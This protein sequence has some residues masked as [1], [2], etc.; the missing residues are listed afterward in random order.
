MRVNIIQN[1]FILN[2]DLFGDVGA[3]DAHGHSD[4]GLLERGRVVD[5]VAR[6]RH[7]GSQPLTAL[8]D[9]QFLLR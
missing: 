7:D 9:N 4:I 3:G 5:A 2:D 1:D 6:H 8:H